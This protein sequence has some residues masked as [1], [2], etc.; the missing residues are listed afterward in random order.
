MALL[1]TT[2]AA[3][4]V[5]IVLLSLDVKSFDALMVAIAMVFVAATAK[6][7]AP[8]LPGNRRPERPTDH[9]TPR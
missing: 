8:S 1:F 2:V 7:I 6:L 3:A 5:W 4:V 9:Y